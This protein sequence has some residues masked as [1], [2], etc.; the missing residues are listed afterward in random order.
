MIRDVIRE[1][2]YRIIRHL[3]NSN[4]LGLRKYLITLLKPII[5]SIYF[6][7]DFDESPYEASSDVRAYS[8]EPLRINGLQEDSGSESDEDEASHDGDD[9]GFEDAGVVREW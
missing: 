5:M 3:E 2:P 7:E 8:Y 1:H 6:D 9:I 4:Q